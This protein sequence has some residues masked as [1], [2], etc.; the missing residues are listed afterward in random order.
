M[1]E[2]ARLTSFVPTQDRLTA[3]NRLTAAMR[4]WKDEMRTLD[5]DMKILDQEAAALHRESQQ[6]LERIQANRSERAR[7]MTLRD[8]Y[9]LAFRRAEDSEE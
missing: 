3:A 7:L 4:V 6:L 9:K 2:V 5:Q 8:G 1:T